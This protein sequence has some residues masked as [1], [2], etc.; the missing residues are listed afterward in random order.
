M[1]LPKGYWTRNNSARI[2]WLREAYLDHPMPGLVAHYNAH[3]AA[4]DGR[5][6]TEPQMRAVLC[7]YQ[8]L[9][10]RVGL[11]KGASSRYWTADRLN[12]LAEHRPQLTAGELVQRFNAHFGTHF[13]GASLL[14]AC[15]RHGIYSERFAP[16]TRER[17]CQIPDD[18]ATATL[19]AA[20]ASDTGAESTSDQGTATGAVPSD[21]SATSSLTIPT[22]TPPRFGDDFQPGGRA[23]ASQFKAGERSINAFPVG[24]Y[25]QNERGYWLYKYREGAEVTTRDHP[26]TPR[27]RRRDSNRNWIFLHRLVWQDHH[28][29]IPPDHVVVFIDGDN[30]NVDI[31]N[32]DCVPRGVH[33][34][35]GRMVTP[36]MTPAERRITLERAKLFI[37]TYRLAREKLGLSYRDIR[38]LYRTPDG[39]LPDVTPT[40]PR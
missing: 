15:I 26:V 33:V 14:S 30:S 8:I 37:Q 29:P 7:N 31:S 19:A 17:P 10:G 16:T 13:S 20:P 35:F 5:L 22:A 6:I 24:S 25:R 11:P 28:G 3:W 39:H 38:A 36:D 27:L 2:A 1:A 21:S 9:C 40:E 23:I 32:L 34:R 12:W 18:L 4:R